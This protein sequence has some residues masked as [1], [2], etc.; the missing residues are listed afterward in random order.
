M[1][2]IFFSDLEGFTSISEG[3]DREA[4]T[5]LLNDYLSA[6]T[7][8]IQEEGGT[9][10]K[11]EGDAIIAFWNA[12]LEQPDHARRCIRAALRCQVRLAEMRPMFRERLGKDLK[13]R[14]GINSGPAIVGNMGSH[15][16]FDYTIIGDAV[17]LASRLEGI[18]KQFGT[19]TIISQASME[20]MDGAFPVR[21]LSRVA[22]V[23]RKEPVVVYEPLPPEDVE[24]RQSQLARFSEGLMRFYK[25]DFP[26]A[27]TVFSGLAD[28]DPAARA[29]MTKCR[30]LI[31]HPPEKWQGVWVITTK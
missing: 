24:R 18:N 31:D 7:D 11:Y 28:A 13:M 14:I 1:L 8:I 25:G 20:Q 30:E 15:N 4:L 5:T 27:E 17:N 19:Y 23:G 29:Y 9:V 2:S 6:M 26:G 12:P 16:R 22:V 10:D 21:E 3:L